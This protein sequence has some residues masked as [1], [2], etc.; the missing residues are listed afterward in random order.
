MLRATLP[1]P[2]PMPLL[3]NPRAAQQPRHPTVVVAGPHGRAPPSRPADQERKN[4][5]DRGRMEDD[6]AAPVGFDWGEEEDWGERDLDAADGNDDDDKPVAASA[7][8]EASEL[9]KRVQEAFDCSPKGSWPCLCCAIDQMYKKKNRSSGAF[10]KKGMESHYQLLHREIWKSRYRSQCKKC[11]NFFKNRELRKIHEDNVLTCSGVLLNIIGEFKESEESF[12]GEKATVSCSLAMKDLLGGD[13]SQVKLSESL[14]GFAPIII[15]LLYKGRLTSLICYAEKSYICFACD[16]YRW[17]KCGT[18]AK[19]V[20]NPQAE[21]YLLA[22]RPNGHDI[23]VPLD[24]ILWLIAIQ[25]RMI[26]IWTLVVVSIAAPLDINPVYEGLHSECK[27]TMVSAVR[28]SVIA[29][30]D[31]FLSYTRVIVWGRDICFAR[32]EKWL[33]YDKTHSEVKEFDSWEKVLEEYSRSSFRPQIIFF[34]RIDPASKA[35]GTEVT[36]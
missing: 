13:E 1:M 8:H 12:E 2:M 23:Q 4:Q 11:Y 5:S 35:A 20:N 24:M 19:L 7:D 26:T 33:V 22:Y 6:D 28:V 29:F 15:T 3:L 27:Y 36:V 32:E 17:L 14:F 31:A 10:N 21:D 9:H 30:S 34:E 18:M 25:V 16:K